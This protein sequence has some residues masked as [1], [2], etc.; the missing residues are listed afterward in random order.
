[1]AVWIQVAQ[2]EEAE[3]LINISQHVSPANGRAFTLEEMQKFVG[4]LIEALPLS[5]GLVV[6]LNEE[7]KLRDL[8]YNAPA[9][10]MAHR[11]SGIAIH[12][13]IVGNVLVA[14]RKETGDDEEEE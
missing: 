6:W 2:A 3:S 11:L 5:N 14:S 13:H 10:M 8:P 7:G 12:D 9:D 1:M 4:G